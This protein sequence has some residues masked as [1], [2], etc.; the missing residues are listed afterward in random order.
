MKND[1]KVVIEELLCYAGRNLD[2]YVED[3]ILRRNNLLDLFKVDSPADAPATGCRPLQ[4]ILDDAVNYAVENKLCEDYE[5]INF[6]TRIMGLVMPMPFQVITTFE[7]LAAVNPSLATKYLYNLSVNSNYIRKVDIDKNIGWKVSN[8]RGDIMI[9]INLSKPEKDPKAILAAKKA[10]QTSYPKCM[11]C[12]ECV[13]F[14]GNANRPARQT[15]RTIPII[16]NGEQWH[17][18]FSPYVY[19]DNHCIALSDEH[20]PM[21]IDGDTFKRMFDFIEFFPDYFIGSNAD[22]PIVGGSI[23]SHDHYQGGSKVLPEMN[24]PAKTYFSHSS[25]PDVKACVVDWYNSVIRL[26][27]AKRKDVEE[28]AEHILKCWREYSDKSVGISA[29]TR[30]EPHN[31]VTPIARFNDENRYV[32]DMILRNNRTDKEHPDGIFHP[33]QDLHNIK[34]EGIGIIEA[35][36]LFILPG[37]LAAEAHLIRDILTGKS[38]LDFKALSDESN[39]LCKH[40]GMIAQLANDFGTGLSDSEAEER[41]TDYINKACERILDCTAVFKHDEEGERAFGRFMTYCGF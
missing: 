34:K 10:P 28:L 6:E 1:I 16:L 15:L 22:L 39:P 9:T 17:F 32:I 33:T 2:M 29:K 4:E 41:V 21:K 40:M 23:L 27:G 25:F 8:P 5:R 38:P 14:S 37:R 20:R 7:Q 30:N 13:G 24:A 12:K 3:Y 35:M 19:F 11:L 18:Q 36:G 31:T 26:E